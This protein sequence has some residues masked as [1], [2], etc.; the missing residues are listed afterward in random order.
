MKSALY[1]NFANKLK[2]QIVEER[3]QIGEK[4]PSIR[5]L[6]REYQLSINTVISG[7]H[8]LEANRVIEAIAKVG[9]FV[10]TPQ[11][12]QNKTKQI[13]HLIA[14]LEAKV[15]HLFHDIMARSAAFDIAPDAEKE[16]P[17]SHLISLNRHINRA[18]RSKVQQKSLY[19]DSPAGSESLR[20]QIKERYRMT[21]VNLSIEDY[22]ITSGCQH[23][24][25]LALFASCQP[26]DNV[27]VESPAFYGVLQLLEQLRLNV[28]EIPAAAPFG[29]DIDS[30]E[31]TLSRWRVKACVLTPA[32]STP[33][34]TSIPL[35]NKKKI[36]ELANQYDLVIIEDDIYGELY[37][38]QRP[39]PIKALDNEGRVILCSSFSK[40]LSRDLRL[41]W[42][43]GGRWHNKIMRAKLV[44]QM[45]NSQAYQQGL[46][47]FIV[48]G[49][50]KRHLSYY[51]NTLKQRRD[52]LTQNIIQF[53]PKSVRYYIPDGGLSMWIELNNNIDTSA[54]YLVALKQ[55]IILTPGALFSMNNYFSNFIRL[56][57]VHPLIGK[58]KLA[59]NNLAKLCHES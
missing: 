19:Y 50:Y 3:W 30:F 58:R 37:F 39:Q 10:A 40:S 33:M 23:S 4:L 48:D 53:W 49:H 11:W 54:I 56:S 47:S 25:F 5:Q 52:Q 8:L 27:I 24:L 34:G 2:Q 20:F 9:Y 26:G 21:G 57:F 1:K 44:S 28:I 55:Q 12:T 59:F 35:E 29:I 16:K 17:S 14:P 36:I 15:P 41:G 31:K 43:S 7:L 32:F 13:K 22:C 42:I 51:R 6:S 45:A 46:T 38:T 18:L